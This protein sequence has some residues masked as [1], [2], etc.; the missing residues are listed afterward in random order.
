[1]GTVTYLLSVVIYVTLMDEIRESFGD[2]FFLTQQYQNKVYDLQSLVSKD[3]I[4]CTYIL[5]L[6][7]FIQ[8][9]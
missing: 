5:S 1:M 4:F 6:N 3:V 2:I 7:T 9:L 8:F